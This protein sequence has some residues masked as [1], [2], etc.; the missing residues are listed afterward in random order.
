MTWR[1]THRASRLHQEGVALAPEPCF[2]RIPWQ[3]WPPFSLTSSTSATWTPTWPWPSPATCRCGHTAPAVPAE[4]T[5]HGRNEGRS[6]ERCLALRSGVPQAV[7]RP[8]L[9]VLVMSATLGG[10]LAE[11][12]A[13]LMGPSAGA[14]GQPV[15]VVVS[16]GRSFPVRTVYLGETQ[17]S[18]LASRRASERSM[19]INRDRA[20]TCARGCRRAWAGAGCAGGGGGRGGGG[21]AGRAGKAQGAARGRAVLPAGRGRDQQV[22]RVAGRRAVRER[23]PL[24]AGRGVFDAQLVWR[25]SPWTAHPMHCRVCCPPRDGCHGGALMCAVVRRSA[26]RLL[27]RRLGGRLDVVQL[28]GGMAPRDQ[29]RVVMHKAPQGSPARCALPSHDVPGGAVRA[30]NTSAHSS[31]TGTKRCPRRAQAGDPGDAHR[32]E[33]PDAQQRVGCRGHGPEAQPR[34]RR[35]HRCQPPAREWHGGR[36][37][38]PAN[39]HWLQPVAKHTGSCSVAGSGSPHD[40]V[41]RGAAQR[42]EVSLWNPLPVPQTERVSAASAEQRAGRAGRQGPG[43]AYRLWEAQDVLAASSPP[44]I[45]QASDGVLPISP[46]PPQ[47]SLACVTP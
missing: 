17:A 1:G 20:T 8:E 42:G 2:L 3:A 22:S 19:A 21:G 26:E 15:P 38:L 5:Q 11:R 28:H 12:C 39:T 34:V 18:K 46:A 25:S 41:Q 37:A 24:G 7:A 14:G 27:L 30:H 10:G 13:A 40:A 43:V 16:Q 36:A 47:H 23:E 45:E 9:R 35:V 33:Q 44:E 31:G 6:C 4:R 32:R 29:D